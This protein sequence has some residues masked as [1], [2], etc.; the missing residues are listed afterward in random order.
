MNRHQALRLAINALEFKLAHYRVNANLAEKFGSHSPQ[1]YAALKQ[2][3]E[4]TQAI[5][6]LQ[7]ELDAHIRYPA[8]VK[9]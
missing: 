1:Y 5:V 3:N 9:L 7:K 2:M 6:I 4:T 8:E